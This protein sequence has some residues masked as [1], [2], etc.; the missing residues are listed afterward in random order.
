MYI[1]FVVN[2][3]G[4]CVKVLYKKLH[5]SVNLPEVKVQVF[6]TSVSVCVYSL[7]LRSSRSACRGQQTYWAFQECFIFFK[8]VN[9]E[10]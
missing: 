10:G 2:K 4:I 8:D 5:Q 7:I 6:N 9:V 1:F 3:K